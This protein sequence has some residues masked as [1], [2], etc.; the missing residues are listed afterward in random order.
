MNLNKMTVED[1]QV[2]GCGVIEMQVRIHIVDM[3]VQQV[4]PALHQ[5][6]EIHRCGEV[7]EGGESVLHAATALLQEWALCTVPVKTGIAS[8][9]VCE[10]QRINGDPAL[11][12]SLQESDVQS[13]IVQVALYV[14]CRYLLDD[15]C[16]DSGVKQD[17]HPCN[18]SRE[19]A[20]NDN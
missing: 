7:V 6:L 14:L 8:V 9:R 20:Q 2:A 12:E 5:F 16:G 18:Q 15:A 1:I 4:Q 17:L 10:C 3:G 13:V 19:H 11:G